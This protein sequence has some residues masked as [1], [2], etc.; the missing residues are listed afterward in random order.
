[1]MTWYPPIAVFAGIIASWFGVGG[2]TV[3]GPLLMEL[4]IL[5]E[6]TTAT[7]STM[8]LFTTISA[9]SGYIAMNRLV[10]FPPFLLFLSL[11]RTTDKCSFQLI[12]TACLLWDSDVLHLNHLHAYCAACLEI[13]YNKALQAFPR[14]IPLCYGLSL[15]C[16][17]HA[18]DKQ[19]YSSGYC[20]WAF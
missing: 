18:P 14:N 10:S 11:S 2:G 13:D 20:A 15:G 19:G 1:M 12:F 17:W 3:K 16:S 8:M 7:S 9:V 4:G 6:V 5:P